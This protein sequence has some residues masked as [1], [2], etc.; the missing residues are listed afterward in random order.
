MLNKK[1]ESCI[2]IVAGDEMKKLMNIKFPN[3]IVIPF[4]E[5]FSK[6]QCNYIDF[7][8]IF[9]EERSTYW[10]I[11]KSEYKKKILPIIN[12][13][14][15][16]TYML[17]FGDDDCCNANLKFIINYLKYKHY[18]KKIKVQILDEY[19]LKIKKEYFVE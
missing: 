8:D 16:K 5:D 2:Y 7:N 18:S 11:S 12:L 4:C 17:C 15:T 6:G 13:D 14:I 3:R 1:T 10:N 9:L 19:S